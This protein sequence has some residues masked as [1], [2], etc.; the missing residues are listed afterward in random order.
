MFQQIKIFLIFSLLLGIIY[1]I[2][3]TIISQITFKNKA[4]GSLVIIDDI[5]RG[6]ELIA[7]EFKDPKYFHS[8]PSAVN[9]NAANSGASNL[10]PSNEK[11]IATVKK[12]IDQIRL[13]N[14]LNPNTLIPAD[15][16]LQSASGLDPHISIDNAN[17][18]KKRIA[19]IRNISE[20]VIDQLIRE[21]LNSRNY[22]NVLKLNLLLDNYINYKK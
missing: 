17:L 21:H 15:M 6:S 12:Q 20:D 9:D 5:V 22:I 14:N 2:A 16:V 7:Q 1:P 4:N 10:G 11:L 18:Q 13:E 3:I 8:R 19:K